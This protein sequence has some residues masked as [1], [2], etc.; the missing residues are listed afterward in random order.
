MHILL[1][2][3]NIIRSTEIQIGL[4][5]KAPNN[6]VFSPNKRHTAGTDYTPLCSFLTARNYGVNPIL[7]D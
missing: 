1:V 4:A 2:V 5:M 6:V 7:K 3:I